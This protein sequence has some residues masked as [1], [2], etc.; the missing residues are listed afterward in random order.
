MSAALERW[1]H[2]PLAEGLG[3]ALFHSLWQGALIAVVL[4]TALGVFRPSSPRVRY[5]LACL[6]LGAFPLVF[7]VTLGLSMPS[8]SA[9]IEALLGEAP[10]TDLSAP[11]AWAEAIRKGLAEPIPQA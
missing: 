6:A 3:W 5:A 11:R 7:G 2:L 10:V 9:G 1:I 8:G 4:A